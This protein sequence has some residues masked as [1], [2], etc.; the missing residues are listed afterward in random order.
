MHQSVIS[1]NKFIS[2]GGNGSSPNVV[3]QFLLNSNNRLTTEFDLNNLASNFDK[4]YGHSV[5]EYS[6]FLII[7]GGKSCASGAILN[8]VL[9]FDLSFVLLILFTN[10]SFFFSIFRTKQIN[11]L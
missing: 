4:R 3:N 1:D 10:Y 9:C 6:N 11:T 5:V 7:F 2:V 8:D